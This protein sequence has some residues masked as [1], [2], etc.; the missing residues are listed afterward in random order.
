MFFLRL[1]QQ[2]WRFGWSATASV[3]E[4][5]PLQRQTAAWLIQRQYRIGN[6]LSLCDVML[7][8]FAKAAP[9]RCAKALVYF[10]LGCMQLLR[11]PA[12][13]YASWVKARATWARARG[14]LSGL[15]GHRYEEY[16]PTR[17][18]GETA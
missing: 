11:L 10:A 3:S 6:G 1:A 18:I 4:Y 12:A 13:P 2:G 14:T 5:I 7:H 16:A 17:L 15:F 8:G 9:L